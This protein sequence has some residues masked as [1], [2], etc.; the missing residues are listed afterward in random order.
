V[1]I[2]QTQKE[3]KRMNHESIR[4]RQSLGQTKKKLAN[5]GFLSL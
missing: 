5:A 1:I 2:N 3:G 4:F